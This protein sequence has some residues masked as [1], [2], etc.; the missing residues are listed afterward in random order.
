MGLA[1]EDRRLRQ[2]ADTIYE[3]QDTLEKLYSDETDV[4]RGPEDLPEDL[5]MGWDEV[6]N[7]L[8]MVM[9]IDEEGL[10]LR[11]EVEEFVEGPYISAR[12]FEEYLREKEGIA[13]V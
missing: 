6:R 13:S 2:L 3:N 7:S 8:T 1:S 9:S 4:Y 12:G 10:S 11:P 5:E